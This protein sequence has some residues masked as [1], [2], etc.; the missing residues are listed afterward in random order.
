MLCSLLKKSRFQSYFPKD[1][2]ELPKS[3]FP[4]LP[5]LNQPIISH[6]AAVL[7][8]SFDFLSYPHRLFLPNRYLNMNSPLIGLDDR[9]SLRVALSYRDVLHE[10]DSVMLDLSGYVIGIHFEVVESVEFTLLAKF[11]GILQ[12]VFLEVPQRFVRHHAIHRST[13]VLQDNLF[14]TYLPSECIE[15]R[16]KEIQGVG[17]DL[18]EWDKNFPSLHATLL[19]LRS[20]KVGD[21]TALDPSKCRPVSKLMPK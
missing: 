1:P 21:F 20:T 6:T 10:D 7:A 5:P 18:E 12:T 9:V 17:D 14:W 11:E 16:A 4:V 2:P 8:Y 3:S 13:F 19:A 15:A